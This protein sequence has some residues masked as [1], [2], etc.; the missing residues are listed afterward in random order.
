MKT[1]I[2]KSL[3]VLAVVML[4]ISVTSCSKGNDIVDPT[5]DN[6]QSDQT[7]SITANNSNNIDYNTNQNNNTGN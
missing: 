1:L 6:N 5:K 7:S 3:V 2:N 4:T